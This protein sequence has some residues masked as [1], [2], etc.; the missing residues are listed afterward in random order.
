MARA[1]DSEKP[2]TEKSKMDKSVAKPGLDKSVFEV[3]IGGVPLKLRSYHD[4]AVVRELVTFVDQRI[5]D[6]LPKVKNGSFQTAAI[7]TSLHLAEELLQLRRLTSRELERLEN[8]AE[9]V[10]ASLEASRIPKTETLTS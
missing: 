5:K 8:R 3:E 1:I 4:E 7:L 2:I 10:I 6:A 9:R